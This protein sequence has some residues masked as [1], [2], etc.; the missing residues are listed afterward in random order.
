MNHSQNYGSQDNANQQ[1]QPQ[2]RFMQQ[3]NSGRVQGGWSQ[4]GNQI[5]HI[6]SSPIYLLTEPYILGNDQHSNPDGF[7]ANK[8]QSNYNRGQPRRGNPY[9]N[10]QRGNSNYSRGNGQQY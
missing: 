10:R 7:V 8:N 5:K 3:S 2:E 6:L 4:S 1:Q 9:Q